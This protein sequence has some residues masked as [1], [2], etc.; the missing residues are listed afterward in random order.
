MCGSGGYG[1]SFHCVL[2]NLHPAFFQKG[3][4][5]ALENELGFPEH[6]LRAEEEA[7]RCPGR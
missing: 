7:Q 3:L 4:E 6:T 2:F 1:M 5:A